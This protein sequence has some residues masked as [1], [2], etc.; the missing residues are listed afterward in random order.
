[1]KI[2]GKSFSFICA[3]LFLIVCMAVFLVSKNKSALPQMVLPKLQ[4]GVDYNVLLKSSDIPPIFE[5]GMLK[6]YRIPLDAGQRYRFESHVGWNE[7][8][9]FLYIDGK[10]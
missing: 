7:I 8:K 9:V 1:M 3:V 4:S 5:Y 6:F 10:K 2:T